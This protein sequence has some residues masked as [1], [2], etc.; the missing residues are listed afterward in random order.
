MVV[1]PFVLGFGFIIIPF[2]I[3]VEL[4]KWHF[5]KNKSKHIKVMYRELQAKHKHNDDNNNEDDD[6]DD[7]EYVYSNYFSN[8]LRS[9]ELIYSFIYST[10]LQI[11]Q[12][13]LLFKFG[14]SIGY[15]FP[16]FFYELEFNNVLINILKC[17][18]SIIFLLVLYSAVLYQVIMKI[19]S[20]PYKTRKRSIEEN[21]VAPILEELEYRGLLFNI[22]RMQGYSN[23]YSGL[24]SSLSFGIAHFRHFF[25]KT[26][27]PAK[28][29]TIFFQVFYTSFFGFYACYIYTVSNTIVSPIIMHGLCNWFS[30]PMFGYRN[31][32]SVSKTQKYII[33]M[34]YICGITLFILSLIFYR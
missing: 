1:S 18:I 29:N 3:V 14:N 19:D 16:Q 10:I 12:I 13:M 23:F 33:H 24:I 7:N 30:L 15:N 27:T 5:N 20:F 32:P 2:Q 6:N 26:Y 11:I 34:L 25:D 28:R 8:E 9:I 4:S 17:F 21:I 22:F 31:D